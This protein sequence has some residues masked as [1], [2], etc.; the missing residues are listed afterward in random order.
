MFPKQLYILIWIDPQATI[1]SDLG[2]SCSNQ[3]NVADTHTHTHSFR[4][5]SELFAGPDCGGRER[6]MMKNE[7]WQ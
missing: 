2:F 3:Y 5:N 4:F 1:K 7:G 6:E